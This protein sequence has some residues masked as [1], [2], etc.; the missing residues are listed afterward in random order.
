MPYSDLIARFPEEVRWP[1]M[2]LIDHLREDLARTVTREDFSELRKAFGELVEAQSRTELR[3][4]ELAEAQTRTEQRLE[5]LA[6]AQKRTERRLE[7]LAEAQKRTER[8]L[9]ELAEAQARTERQVARTEQRLEELAEAQTRTE[10]RLDRLA[11]A[12]ERTERRLD[13]LAEAQERT[14]RQVARLTGEVVRIKENLGGLSHTVGYRLEDEAIWS[15]PGL[16]ERDHGIVVEG[17]L[18]RDHLETRP[19][20]YEELNIWGEGA[21]GGE[22]VHILGEAKSQLKK[23]DVDDFLKLL[24]RVQAVVDRPLVRLVV[25]YQTS[26]QVK[27]YLSEKGILLYLSYE[28]GRK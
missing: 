4:E 10:R 15:L 13:R 8:R 17:S 26:P 12:Q 18:R 20:R 24:D 23:R 27:R 11:E 6:E 7:E 21:R 22:R 25:T 19:N 5:E 28:L 9:E 1:M 14:E 2:E 16:L 3:L